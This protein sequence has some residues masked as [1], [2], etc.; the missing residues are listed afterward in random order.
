MGD[1]YVQPYTII[2][3]TI[4]LSAVCIALD[5]TG[6]LSYLAM[7]TMNTFA[8]TKLRLFLLLFVFSAAFGATTSNDLVVMAMTNIHLLL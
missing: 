7:L 4:S 2:L 6:A 3:L 1:G 5:H 8:T